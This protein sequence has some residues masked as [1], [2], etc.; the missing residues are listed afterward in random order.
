MTGTVFVK[1]YA[2]PPWNTRE[3]LRYASCKG[4]DGRMT[5]LMEKCIAEIEPLL[6]YRV[7]FARFS[8]EAAEDMLNLGF[9][10][11][12]SSALAK[13]LSSCGEI[14]LFAATV[15]LAPDRLT[16]RYA[17]VSP[18]KSL[19]FDAIGSKLIGHQLH[20][21]G[22]S[23]TADAGNDLDHFRV[24]ECLELFQIDRSVSKV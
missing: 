21:T 12:Q 3:I 4:A 7:C 18:A 5:A 8:V 16:A 17:S 22:F 10:R 11:V 15:G 24:P 14:V 23:A 13:N 6:S 1:N 2:P 20:Q 19:F 9:A